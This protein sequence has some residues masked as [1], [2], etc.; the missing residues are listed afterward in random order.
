MADYVGFVVYTA[1]AI[2]AEC[3]VYKWMISGVKKEEI[4]Y[5][6]KQK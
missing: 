2:A 1:I 6:S 4:E 5:A 3:A